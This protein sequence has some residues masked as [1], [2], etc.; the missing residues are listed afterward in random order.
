MEKIIAIAT[1]FIFLTSCKKNKIYIDKN[2][3]F[4][5]AFLTNFENIRIYTKNGQ[6]NNPTLAQKYAAEFSDYFFKNSS[7]FIDAEFQK[8]IFVN[9]DSIINIS[10][11]PHLETKRKNIDT[12]DRYIGNRSELVNDTNTLNLYI[13]KYKILDKGM[14]STGYT[15][16]EIQKPTYFIKKKDDTLFFPIVSYIL[17]SRRPFITKLFSDK[18][19]NV[20]SEEGVSKLNESDTLVVQSFDLAFK[21][22]K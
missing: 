19:N 17:I 10:S 22:N 2:Q 21:K 8:F 7:S 15:Y 5:N 1:F 3:Y 6:I 13:I 11:N 9:E 12:Y 16:Y 20:F 18:F 14:S 4:E